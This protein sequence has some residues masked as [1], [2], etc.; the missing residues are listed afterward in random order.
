MSTTTTNTSAKPS[1]SLRVASLTANV[2]QVS[3]KTQGV[4]LDAYVNAY[5]APYANM[6]LVF[7]FI[8]LISYIVWISTSTSTINE[9]NVALVS[10]ILLCCAYIGAVISLYNSSGYGLLTAYIV[11]VTLI[12][13][14]HGFTKFKINRTTTTMGVTTTEKTHSTSSFFAMISSYLAIGFGV[15]Q[16]LL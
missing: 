9:Y 6:S 14:I 3:K 11:S 13:I 15:L 10:V 16:I 2:N 4:S 1:Q 5:N 8:A 12:I 7:M